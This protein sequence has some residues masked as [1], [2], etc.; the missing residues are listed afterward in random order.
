MTEATLDRVAGLLGELPALPVVAQQA[1]SLLADPAAEPEALQS[2]LSRDPA[3]AVKVLSQA[4]SAYYRRNRAITTLGGAVVLLG[5]KTIQTLILSSAVHR[6]LQGAGPWG[7]ALWL[8]CFGA[9]LAGR[10]LARRARGRGGVPEE[11]FLVG[12]F[13]DVGKGLL[14]AKLPR[15][16]DNAPGWAGEEADLGFHHGTLGQALLLRWSIPETLAEAVGEHHRAE[17]GGLPGVARA[18]DW[19]AWSVAPGVG[20]LPYPRPDGNLE[21]L[22]LGDDDLTDLRESLAESLSEE[23]GGVA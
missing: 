9:G 20:A 8:H 18:A 19:L 16:Y 17:G 3:L 2:V 23:G 22:G 11:A 21:A 12:L 5:F 4:N 14:A 15:L 13:H 6:V 7:Q 1:L 10:E